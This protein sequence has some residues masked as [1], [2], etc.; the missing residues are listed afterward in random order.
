MPPSIRSLTGLSASLLVA[1][2]LSVPVAA[3]AANLG[4]LRD[5]PLSQMRQADFDS[6]TKAV[7]AALDDKHDGESATWTN[8][9]L[10]NSVRVSATITPGQTG[11]NGDDTCRTAVVA[12]VAR[13]QSMTLRP[14]FCRSG[15]GAWVYQK[16]H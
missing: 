7:H 9:G 12:I 10:R 13:Q 3:S 6:L 4:F 2:G 1:I 15:S 5:T 14:R 8:E 11:A 16:T